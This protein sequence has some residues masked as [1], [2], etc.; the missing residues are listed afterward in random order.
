MSQVA[1]VPVRFKLPTRIYNDMKNIFIIYF[2]RNLHHCSVSRDC[3]HLCCGRSLSFPL[4][5]KSIRG[6]QILILAITYFP[7]SITPLFFWA[8][9]CR[10]L[11]TP[12]ARPYPQVRPRAQGCLAADPDPGLLISESKIQPPPWIQCPP[13]LWLHRGGLPRPTAL[14]LPWHPSFVARPPP[15]QETYDR[16]ALQFSMIWIK[17]P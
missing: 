10:C 1:P 14:C 4:T 12:M 13:P 7:I 2:S 3:H 11:V 6:L 9:L 17:T 16:E 5:N 8:S 15:S